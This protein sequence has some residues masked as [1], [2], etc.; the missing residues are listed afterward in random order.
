MTDLG[1]LG[2]FMLCCFGA[3]VLI[4]LLYR[5]IKNKIERQRALN[6]LNKRNIRNNGQSDIMDK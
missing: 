5:I 3:G 1:I 2:L 6:T 4:F